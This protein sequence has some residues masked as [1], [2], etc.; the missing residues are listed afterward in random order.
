[1]ARGKLVIIGVAVLLLLGGGAAAAYFLVPSVRTM[2]GGKPPKEAAEPEKP[3]A[4]DPKLM[5]FADLKAITA[6][7][8]DRDGH[9]RLVRIS[10]SLQLD[11][12]EDKARIEAY[13]PR[14]LDAIQIR[15]RRETVEDL[16]SV[17]GRDTLR[18]DLTAAIN[19]EIAPGHCQAILFREFII[20]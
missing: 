11:K 9:S 5:G 3:A 20:E 15:L 7:I 16:N 2:L 8:R 4:P 14:I 18:D 13:L 10:A 19:Q 17:K 6:S 12:A 1:M